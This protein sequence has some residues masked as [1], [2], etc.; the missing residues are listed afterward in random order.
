MEE[1]ARFADEKRLQLL[2]AEALQ[3]S[4]TGKPLPKNADPY[5][6]CVDLVKAWFGG[7]P[8]GRKPK[9]CRVVALIRTIRG[10]SPKR[11]T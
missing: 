1:E 6:E 9:W 3:P 7:L 4:P 11:G 5:E 10:R 2:R 8:P